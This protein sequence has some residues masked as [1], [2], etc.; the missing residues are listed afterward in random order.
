MRD[1]IDPE[2][3]VTR[4]REIDPHD[5][6]VDEHCSATTATASHFE[7]SRRDDLCID[8]IVALRA[9]EHD[10]GR[11]RHRISVLF[12]RFWSTDRRREPLAPTATADRSPTAQR[13]AKRSH[14][15]RTSSF[16]RN[17]V[18][19]V[20]MVRSC[21]MNHVAK[22]GADGWRRSRIAVSCRSRSRFCE[23]HRRHAA[24]TLSHSCLPPRLRGTTWSMLSASAPQYWHW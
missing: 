24:T 19:A 11:G 6:R 3:I 10:G 9:T 23:L 16:C 22:C 1:V 5:R 7:P 8:E 21:N 15:L 12:A 14:A 4:D 20:G 13:R 18:H 2:R 17:G